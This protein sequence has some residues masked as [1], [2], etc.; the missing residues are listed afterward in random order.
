MAALMVG[1]APT[2]D[3]YL[4]AESTDVAPTAG[5][6]PPYGTTG[7]PDGFEHPSGYRVGAGDTLN[8]RVYSQDD[9]N[10]DY[11]VD[12]AGNIS[13]PLVGTVNVAK[14]TTPQIARTLEKRLSQKYLRD[15][16]VS[17]QVANMRPFFVVGEVRTPGAFPYMPGLTVQEAIALSGGYTPRA[18]QGAVLVSRRSSTGVQNINLPVLAPLYPGDVVYVK[19]RWF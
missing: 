7:I 13:M 12:A 9:L 5:L 14:L 16:S 4:P 19:E 1:C 11:R 18:D 10:G 3:Q 15:P 17:V 8:I 2:W 6:N